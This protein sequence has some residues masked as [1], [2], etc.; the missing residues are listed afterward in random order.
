MDW[1]KLKKEYVKGGTSY[2]QLSEKYGVPF[3]TLRNVAAK[4]GWKKLRDKAVTKADSIMVEKVSAKNAEIDATVFEAAMLLL[5]AYMKSVRAFEDGVSPIPPSMLKDYGTALKS[6][7]AVLEKPTDLDI[8][9]QEARIAKLQRDAQKEDD[10]PSEVT[11]NIA[12]GDASW[13]S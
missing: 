1:T 8:K 3:G 4:E 9:E 11:V 6:I 12:G 7:Q 10:G 5:K 2:R 13:Q